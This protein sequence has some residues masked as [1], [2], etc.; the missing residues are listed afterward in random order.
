MSIEQ[1]DLAGT[2]ITDEGLSHIIGLPR[3]EFLDLSGTDVSDNAV[4][5]LKRIPSLKS[6]VLLNT[7]L[8]LEGRRRMAKEIPSVR[9]RASVG[10]GHG[11]S[12][13]GNGTVQ[14]ESRR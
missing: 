11:G 10:G 6:V 1:L 13:G 9:V 4:D 8:T 2:R 12:Y 5:H 7:K 3:L 14:T